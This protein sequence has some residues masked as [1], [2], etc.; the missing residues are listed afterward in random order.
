M[1][2]CLVGE[3]SCNLTMTR[4]VGDESDGS[5]GNAEVDIAVY[6]GFSSKGEPRCIS[7]AA[8]PVIGRIENVLVRNNVHRNSLKVEVATEE[9]SL[10]VTCLHD[11]DNGSEPTNSDPTSYS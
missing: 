9:C 3:S 8:D 10:P 5:F 7:I 2:I 4:K 1:L 6:R 11:N